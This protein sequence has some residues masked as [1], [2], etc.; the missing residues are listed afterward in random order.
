MANLGTLMAFLGVDTSD[1]KRAEVD[2][3]RFT[4]TT[5]KK[6]KQ[7]DKSTVALGTAFK[8]LAVAV[9]A[10]KVA[11]VAANAI[12]EGARYKTLG[13]VMETVG[14]NA[15]FSAEQMQGFALG[16]Q[17]TGIAMTESRLNL[18]KMAQAQLDL[19]K[20]SEL[21]RVA[22]DAAVIGHVD[23]S[24]AF[25]KLIHA[26]QTGRVAVLQTIGLNV[27][28]GQSYKK[29]ADELGITTSELTEGQKASA[30]LNIVLEKGKNIAGAYEAAMDTASKKLGSLIRPLKNLSVTFGEAFDPEL[31]KVVD[32]ITRS[33]K[34]L[35]KHIAQPEVQKSLRDTAAGLGLIAA[36]SIW[37]AKQAGKT[38]VILENQLNIVGKYAA[39]VNA[40]QGLFDAIG[41]PQNLEGA[42]EEAIAAAAAAEK[43]RINAEKLVEARAAIEHQA[44][45]DRI[46]TLQAT[47]SV[48]K[49]SLQDRL[50]TYT[51]FYND[52]Q[53]KI[54][55]NFEAEKENLQ[56]LNNL[57][58]QQTSI[59]R[60]T[61]GL[62]A[63]LGGGTLSDSA[64]FA[65]TSRE[66]RRQFESAL[67]LEGSAQV[68]ALEAY[69][70]SVAE[71]AE[72]FKEGFGHKEGSEIARQAI[73]D[74]QA[75][76]NI[77]RDTLEDLTAATEN[78]IETDKL[79]G[80]TLVAESS[81][82][83]TEIEMLQELMTTLN[84]QIQAMDT[85]VTLDINDLA[86]SEV[87]RI[88]QEIQSIKDKTVTITTR[89]ITVFGEGGGDGSPAPVL[90]SLAVG[91]N[92]IPEDGLYELH[93][94]EAV[95]PA[96]KN[97]GG[98]G[99]GMG[100]RD[101]NIDARGSNMSAP[102]WRKVVR[103]QIIPE[104]KNVMHNELRRGRN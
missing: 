39:A 70:Q 69:K 75:A 20:S 46:N 73:Q 8:Q 79:W 13:V 38:T 43:L 59:R 28:F 10:Y 6:M 71:L 34:D 26:I 3:K 25:S 57:Y 93:R 36:S 42:K 82:A 77:Q 68:D 23:S 50:T 18:A 99:D 52:L 32:E 76:Y 96:D 66:L 40:F 86:T 102:E 62:V 17:K 53:N 9:G 95:I 89:H 60:S 49:D 91:S 14:R 24:A 15:G 31:A 87:N 104:I 7:A 74:I 27:S 65:T 1:L 30:R 101:I 35:T 78:Q 97:A 16:L 45:L 12:L 94:G 51:D 103:D 19:N 81:K 85:L 44:N 11:Q 80:Q 63:T 100:F 5:Q 67:D 72:E 41:D 55:E 83:A 29:L 47:A 98:Q 64:Q 92:F 37:A 88:E 22:Q 56:N 84:E 54:K 2:M 21:A 90:D 61:E 48:E 33:I 58:R 4:D